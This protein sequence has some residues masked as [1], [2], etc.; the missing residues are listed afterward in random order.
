MIT[1]SELHTIATLRAELIV[2]LIVSI[3]C[4][5]L[6]LEWYPILFTYSFERLQ[7]EKELM[8]PKSEKISG[9]QECLHNQILLSI[10]RDFYSFQK[11]ALVFM[12]LA[13]NGILSK[14]MRKCLVEM[15]LGISCM[16]VLQLK[17]GEVVARMHPES[18]Y[19]VQKTNDCLIPGLHDDI[20][21]ECLTLA[22]RSDYPSLA[23][24]NKNFHSLIGSGYLYKLR[25][26]LG[27][28]EHWVYLA[29]SLM[30]WEA[31]DPTRLRWM[32]LPRMPCDECFSYA[33]KESLAVNSTSSVW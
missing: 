32:R 6:L 33:D 26:Q 15:D 19:K 31:F 20:A 28:I 7:G 25:R 29:C 16:N 3:S 11:C 18:I 2:F 21:I 24:L 9:S 17:N 12:V 8:A 30:P 22:C 4:V 1:S 13:K 5:G 14:G 23:C 10:K 27:I